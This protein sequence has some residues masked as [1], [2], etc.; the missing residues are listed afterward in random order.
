MMPHLTLRLTLGTLLLCVVTV[1]A[2][3]TSSPAPAG[4][5]PAAD[6]VRQGQ[7]KARE[8]QHEEA[9]AIYR[10]ALA[11]WPDSFPAHLQTGVVLDL[12][13]QYA[14]ART[15]LAKAI[16]IAPTPENKAQALRTMAMSYAFE[17]KCSDAAR[18]ASQVY[19]TQIAGKNFVNAGE[20]ANELARVCLESDDL[21]EAAKWYQ[22][23]HE[24]GLQEPDLKPERR[25]L[26]DFRWEHAQARVA[27]RRG[28]AAEAQTHVAAARAIFAERG[29]FRTSSRNSRSAS[30]SLL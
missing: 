22:R 13:G 1:S 6:L 15:H 24:A 8:G 18:Y 14:E 28:Q 10:Q 17:R 16:E 2:Q 25:D 29:Y 27:A 3:P 23:G 11:K 20:V 4:Q 7:Q 12:N 9:L 21:D 30:R 19:E 26:W 5:D